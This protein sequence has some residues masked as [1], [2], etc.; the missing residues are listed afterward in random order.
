MPQRLPLCESLTVEFKSDLKKLPDRELIEA[1]VCLANAEGGEL[2]LG[3]EDDGTPTG[4]HAEHRLLEGL[5]GMVAARTSPSLNVQAEAVDMDGVTVAR[6]Q[7]PKAQGEVATTSGVYLRRRLKHDGTPECV[8]MLPHERSSRASSFGQLDVSAQPVAGATLADLDPLERER[9]RQAVQ[10]YGG[11]R[12]LLEL[13]D[14]ALD[15]ALLLTARQA[16]GSR[17][18]TLTGLLLIGRETSLR[19][20]V[21]AHEFA[22]QVL[23]QQAVRFNEFRRFPLLKALDW[24][25]TNFRPYNPE[26]EL[27]VGLF[28]VPVPKVDL[29]AFREAVANALV[30]RDYHGRGAV[31]VRLEDAALVVSNPGGLVDGVTLANLLVTEPRPRNPALADAMKRI[32][33]VERSGRGVDKIF[34]GMLKFGRPAPDYSYTTAQSVVLRLPTAEADLDFRRLVVEHERATNAELPIDSL[35]ALAALRESKR[36]T[37]DEL[38]LQIQRDTASAK[39]T[40]EAL[41]EAGLVEA[42]GS[43]RGRS[44]TLSAS[45]YQAVGNKAAYTRQAGFAPI[46]HEQ[47]VLNYVQQHGQIKRAEVM[48]LCRISTDQAAKLLKKLKDKGAIVQSGKNRGATYTLCILE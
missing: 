41:T 1:L 2:W 45:L 5:A 21:P 14:E 24:L 12:V 40:L 48:G 29:G 3:V 33:V 22:F 19:Q 7:V 37:A 15:G 47:M 36:V 43:T 39:R 16:D 9:L 42:H 26:E 11:D 44:Y 6:I 17:V 27:Q 38:A 18:P 30:H 35:I 31:H 46:Q 8:A 10:Q 32:G 25:E 34:R 28:R 23:A 13:D 4:L 20:L